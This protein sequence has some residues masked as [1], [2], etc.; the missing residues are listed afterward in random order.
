MGLGVMS[1]SSPGSLAMDVEGEDAQPTQ[2]YEHDESR[3]FGPAPQR[4]LRVPPRGQKPLKNHGQIRFLKKSLKSYLILIFL[5]DYF[6]HSK[7]LAFSNVLWSFS[8]TFH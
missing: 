8:T 6:L 7:L 2:V 1:E 5:A 4:R 3:H